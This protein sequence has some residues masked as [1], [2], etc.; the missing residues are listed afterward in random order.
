MIFS[1][2]NSIHKILVLI[3][4]TDELGAASKPILFVL[5]PIHDDSVVST[6]LCLPDTN[7]LKGLQNL[8]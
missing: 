2:M 1:E 8:V 7:T 3:N 4:C 6:L 5:L